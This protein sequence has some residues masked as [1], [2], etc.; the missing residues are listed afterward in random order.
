[1]SHTRSCWL[2]LEAMDF[3][4][5]TIVVGSA[6]ISAAR[7]PWVAQSTQARSVLFLWTAGTFVCHR[8]RTILSLLGASSLEHVGIDHAI[9]T[10][11]TTARVLNLHV[12]VLHIGIKRL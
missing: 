7:R 6:V 5:W 9:L 10:R 8:L 11:V 12:L 4:S 2:T 1:M 3:A